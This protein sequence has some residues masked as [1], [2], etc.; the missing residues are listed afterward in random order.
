MPTITTGFQQNPPLSSCLAH[1]SSTC[2]CRAVR[3]PAHTNLSCN[4]TQTW[5]RKTKSTPSIF[6]KTTYCCAALRCCRGPSPWLPESCGRSA[7]TQRS[8]EPSNTMR[9]IRSISIPDRLSVGIVRPRL[10]VS[11]R[12]SGRQPQGA[13]ARIHNSVT[14]WPYKGSTGGLERD[15]LPGYARSAPDK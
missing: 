15:L 6:R 4:T 8:R 2:L 7:V 3:Q 1:A 9:T 11:F 13:Y 5:K 14:C 10:R 12:T